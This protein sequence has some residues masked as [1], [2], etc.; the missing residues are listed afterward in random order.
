[1]YGIR[2]RAGHWFGCYIAKATDTTYRIVLNDSSKA[3]VVR[4]TAMLVSIPFFFVCDIIGS[5]L[6][7]GSVYKASWKHIQKTAE[8]I[9][10][11]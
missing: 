11:V 6:R 10:F 9:L 5:W 2:E 1:M 3:C 7:L 8:V 4:K